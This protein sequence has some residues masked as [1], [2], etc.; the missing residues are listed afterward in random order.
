MIR[1]AVV[2][3]IA[4]DACL[5]APPVMPTGGAWWQA[6]PTDFA[7]RDEGFELAPWDRL[8]VDAT[9]AFD[10]LVRT[11]AALSLSTLAVPPGYNPLTLS[12]ARRDA[13]A[14][15]RLARAGD[16][17]AFFRP[18]TG[19]PRV[20]VRPTR[21]GFRPARGVVES[22]RFESTF[23]PF[24]ERL[25]E[26][27]RR[28]RA[29]RYAHVRYW[30]HDRGPR[31]TIVAIHGFG[32]EGYDLNQWFFGLPWLYDALGVDVALFNLPFHGRRQTA[33]S[34][35]SGHGFFAGGPSRMN[36]AFAQAV[37][38]FRQLVT[39]LRDDRGVERVGV[40]GISLGGFTTAL[41]AATEPR[42]S[43][44]IPN[45][46]VASIPDLLLEWEPMGVIVRGLL[47]LYGVDMVEA[48]RLVAVSSPLTWKPQLPRER[49]MVIGGVGDRLASPK[50]SRLLWDHW[51]RCRLH[52]FPGSHLLHLDRGGY[53]LEI[54]RF[55][56]S[57]G[58][59]DGLG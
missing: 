48:R 55:L 46:P 18:P 14:S 16:P 24:T 11:S 36:E 52:W 34:P 4:H 26:P 59:L 1:S 30:R 40:T 2:S 37:H 39:Y 20:R 25:R 44:A 35:F 53:Q 32:A 5:E 57:V 29:N 7:L 43:F 47:A 6:L 3:K 23:E 31:P 8:R 58:F 49:L 41:L 56:R 13:E 21:R 19:P 15:E 9:A 10:V 33:L 50:H 17:Y 22:L 27:Y 54:A 38:D 45:V 12:R 42:L 28:H 51:G